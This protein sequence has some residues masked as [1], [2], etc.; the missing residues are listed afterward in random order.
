MRYTGTCSICGTKAPAR[1]QAI[2]DPVSKTVRC[3]TCQV[4]T[5]AAVG[6]ERL[7]AHLNSLSSPTLIVLHDRRIPKTRANIDH[8]VIAESGVWV[9]DTKRYKGRPQLKIE[10]GLRRP[11][12]EKLIVGRRDCAKLVDGVLKQVDL[13][14][15]L[16]APIPVAGILCFIDAD[17]H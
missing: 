13:V 10:G 12:V 2:Y 7:G 15:N 11:C 4:P 17:S 8:M 9:I 5:D 1:T 6:E 14:A 16:V 3:L